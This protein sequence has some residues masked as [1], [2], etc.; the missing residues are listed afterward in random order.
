LVKREAGLAAQ[1]L[2]KKYPELASQIPAPQPKPQTKD[3]GKPGTPS[4]N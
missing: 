1:A 3:G 4:V 2:L